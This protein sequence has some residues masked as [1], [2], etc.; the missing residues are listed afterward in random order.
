MGSLNLG[1]VAALLVFWVVITGAVAVRPFANPYRVGVLIFRPPFHL[2]LDGLREGL[3]Q[4]G[5]REAENLAFVVEDARG[6]VPS[7]TGRA[8]KIV[9]AKPDAMFTIGTAPTA[10]AK[11]A[12]T[13]L[14]IVLTFVAD[15][16][17]SGLIASYASS[18]NNLTGITSSAA[19]LSGKRLELLQEIAP[20]IKHVLVL[21]A[22][23]ES[24]SEVSFK[25]L[26]EVAPKLGIE[27]IRRDVSSRAEIEQALQALPKGTIDAIYHISSGLVGTHID[28]L[29]QR[30]IEDRI[31][32]SVT[33][34]AMVAQGALISFGADIRLLGEQAAKLV[35]KI[36]TGAKPS[37]IPVQVAEKLTLVINLSTAKAIGLDIPRTILE[38]TDRF[39]E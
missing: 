36:L 19:P 38:Q 4:L 23:Q 37:E 5:Y 30:A 7:L 26:A 22:P 16:L 33:E 25:F 12:T 29:I 6:D 14:P 27:L 1:L 2:A 28:L 13:M 24:V 11:Q 39:V 20:G 32:L 35:A 8:A 15:P 21:V 9:Q 3:A 34:D 17:R 18:Q 31:P 10:A